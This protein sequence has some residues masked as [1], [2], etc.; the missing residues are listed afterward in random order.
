M[1]TVVFSS[2]DRAFRSYMESLY[3]GEERYSNVIN[4]IGLF[5]ISNSSAVR[6]RY[7]VY[8][9]SLEEKYPLK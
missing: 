3:G 8:V 9:K 2:T 1:H 7:R 5:T 6:S 4:G